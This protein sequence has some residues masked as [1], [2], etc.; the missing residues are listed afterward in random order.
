M[1]AGGLQVG[2]PADI[3]FLAPE[4]T[5]EISAASFRS[6]GRNTPFDGWKLQGAVAGTMVQ[7]RMVYKASDVTGAE[8]FD[9][10][11]AS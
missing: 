7:G 8:A 3:T 5:V 4:S 2:K 9:E 1:E 10:V 11:D 6:K